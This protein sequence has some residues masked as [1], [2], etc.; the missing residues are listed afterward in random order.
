MILPFI[1]LD[2][3][4]T[5]M[6]PFTGGSL[7]ND[8][9]LVIGIKMKNIWSYTTNIMKNKS[10]YRFLY[11]N[12]DVIGKTHHEKFKNIMNDKIK[13]NVIIAS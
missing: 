4:T 12:N 10:I 6:P 2:L 13:S 5:T 1:N 8:S 3:T 9:I 7:I 11:T